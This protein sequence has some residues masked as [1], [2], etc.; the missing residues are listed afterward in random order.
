MEIWMQPEF[1]VGVIE[2]MPTW[3]QVMARFFA[4]KNPVLMV[5]LLA[6]RMRRVASSISVI[7]AALFAVFFPSPKL[8]YSY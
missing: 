6:L 5:W 4:T 3:E 7:V 2:L 1:M 8:G